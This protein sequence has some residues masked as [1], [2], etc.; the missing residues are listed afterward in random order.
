[1]NIERAKEVERLGH[2]LSQVADDLYRVLY[3]ETLSMERLGINGSAEM[4]QKFRMLDQHYWTIK[5]LADDLDAVMD[6]HRP[7][8]KLPKGYR[9]KPWEKFNSFLPGRK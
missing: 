5:S 1:V 2:A 4:H 9:R 7:M 8:D 6:R 3:E